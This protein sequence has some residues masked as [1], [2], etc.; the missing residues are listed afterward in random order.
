[1]GKAQIISLVLTTLVI[2]ILWF[3]FKFLQ[4]E[5]MNPTSLRLFVLAAVILLSKVGL[6]VSTTLKTKRDKIILLCIICLIAVVSMTV[7]ESL[8]K[9]IKADRTSIHGTSKG[10]FY[11][12]EVYLLILYYIVYYGASA[13]FFIGAFFAIIWSMV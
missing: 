5:Q 3:A 11:N 2:C 1:M 8:I 7:C 4:L 9:R 6:I 10:P 12:V 13:T